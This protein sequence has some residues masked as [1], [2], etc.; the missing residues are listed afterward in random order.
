[1]GTNVT[2]CVRTRN[3][4]Q[5]F[6]EQMAACEIHTLPIDSNEWGDDRRKRMDRVLSRKSDLLKIKRVLLKMASPEGLPVSGRP[7]RLTP[8]MMEHLLTEFTIGSDKIER[9]YGAQ[10]DK[11][12]ARYKADCY[13]QT[14]NKALDRV[15]A[16]FVGTG[17]FP[18]RSRSCGNHA[19]MERNDFGYLVNNNGK[20]H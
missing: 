9:L 4:L 17:I 18:V 12:K 2:K 1:M 14:L 11:R 15:D 10:T 8:R 6:F 7:L 13:R 19:A 3:K 20:K 16:A 5:W